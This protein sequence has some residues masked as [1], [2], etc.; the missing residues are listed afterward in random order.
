MSFGFARKRIPQPR[1]VRLSGIS[2]SKL[3][4]APEVE[5]V[6]FTKHTPKETPE[7]NAIQKT[8]AMTI[9]RKGGELSDFEIAKQ[10]ETIAL[11]MFPQS[12][13]IGKALDAFYKTELGKIALGYAAQ[14]KYPELQK[15]V[16][17]G[18]G[19]LRVEKGD[20]VPLKAAPHVHREKHG[21]NEAR[22]KLAS[23]CD[24]VAASHAAAHGISKDKAYSDLLHSDAAF[25]MVM[26]KAK[27]SPFASPH[28]TDG[29]NY[30]DQQT[31]GR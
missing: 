28:G 23:Y 13:N 21:N 18:D 20:V 24:S 11:E 27:G 17:G 3:D 26:D 12:E 6:E 15:S 22:A 7:M 1:R 10:H 29:E 4:P 5:R 19:D 9:A 30:D 25:R 16:R 14:T 31:N 2:L 8:L